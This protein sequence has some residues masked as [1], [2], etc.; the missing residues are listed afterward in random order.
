MTHLYNYKLYRILVLPYLFFSLLFTLV[1]TT[2]TF[3]LHQ[4]LPRQ[5]L[6]SEQKTLRAAERIYIATDRDSYVAG[7]TM[8]I[9]VYC[10][11][12]SDSVSLSNMSSIAYLELYNAQSLVLTAKIALVAGRGSGHIEL[13]PNLPTGNYKIASYTK[14]MLNEQ[15]PVLFEKFISIYNVLSSNRVEGN[16]TTGVK[17]V[18]NSGSF[19]LSNLGEQNIVDIS[20]G[21]S[22]RIVP[23]ENSFVFSLINNGESSISANISIFR[24]DSLSNNYNKSFVQYLSPSLTATPVFTNKFIPE[25]EGEIIYGKVI[26]DNNDALW[27]KAIFLSAAGGISDIYSTYVDSVG[28]FTFFTTPFF[29]NRDLILEIPKADSNLNIV[30]DIYDPFIRENR[31]EIP[32]LVLDTNIISSLEQRGVEMQLGRRFRIDTLFERIPMDKDPLL[33]SN[34]SVYRLDDYTRFTVMQEVVSEF[35]PELRFR[36]VDKKPDLQVRLNSS[37][38][39]LAFSNDNTLAILDGVAVFDHQKIEEYNPLKVETISIYNSDYYIG[40]AAFSGIASFKTYKGDYS[41]LSFN[42]NVR[43]MDYQG[44]LYPSKMSASTV[45]FFK[46]IPDMRSML[47][48]DPIVSFAPKEKREII[49]HTSAL[50]GDYVILVEGISFNGIPFVYSTEF[51]VK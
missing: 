37:F 25:Y 50:P 35:I 34:L 3:A 18:K 44:V 41:G 16:V 45:R 49:V 42:K 46:N 43:I 10:V 29:G 51:V 8:W 2:P 48:W 15:E 36:K 38:K 7:E 9:S 31:G 40:V 20:F 1:A 27:D 22:G 23:T 24:Q 14:Q 47:Y 11:D 17:G 30:Y 4:T 19:S 28:N 13:P 26:C 39:E 5:K 12:V 33:Q 21:A 6:S 32:T